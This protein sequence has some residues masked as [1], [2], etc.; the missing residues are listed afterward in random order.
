[1]S[2]TDGEDTGPTRMRPSTLHPDAGRAWL[3]GGVVG[4]GVR[5]SRVGVAGPERAGLR[6]GVVGP[7]WKWSGA[8]GV[9]SRRTMPK[10]GG[11]EPQFATDRGGVGGPVWT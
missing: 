1:M 8:G 3:R 4:P 11:L 2:S 10:G 6:V 9:G 7:G 5:K